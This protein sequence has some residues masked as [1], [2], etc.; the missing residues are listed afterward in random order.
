MGSLRKEMAVSNWLVW[1][2]N[3]SIHWSGWN[4]KTQVS[5]VVH[6]KKKI[7][8][9]SDYPKELDRSTGGWKTIFR[10]SKSIGLPS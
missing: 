7:H 5:G 3:R 6:N 1:A 8:K 9:P 2:H 10:K 4:S